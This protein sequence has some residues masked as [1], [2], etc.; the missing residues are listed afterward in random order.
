MKKLT[1]FLLFGLLFQSLLAGC[2]GRGSTDT[3]MTKPAYT[4][5]QELKLKIRELADQ[6]LATTPNT[7]ISDLVAMPTSFVDLDNKRQTSALG[8]LFAESLIYEFNQR[9]YPVCEYRLTGNIDMILGQGDFALLRQGLM[10]TTGKN[11][12]ALIVGTYYVTDDSVFVNARLVRA[13]DGMVLRTGQ[14]LLP[15]NGLIASMVKPLG[16]DGASYAA[17][18]GSGQNKNSQYASNAGVGTLPADSVAVTS[19]QCTAL[20]TKGK[21]RI[22][23]APWKRQTRRR[24]PGPGLYSS[25]MQ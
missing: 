22:V 11:W 5:A 24:N 3:I 25:P 2:V 9:A 19:N 12:A 18:G 15:K 1:I 20:L 7:G 16:T 17:N 6:L 13:S 4:D 10:Q 21:M 8:N 14:I 23:P